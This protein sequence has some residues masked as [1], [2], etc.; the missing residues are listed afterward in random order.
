VVPTAREPRLKPEPIFL[1]LPFDLLTH[2]P[3]GSD[4]DDALGTLGGPVLFKRA[5]EQGQIV[6][7]LVKYL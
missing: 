7:S 2:R 1:L 4:V 6:G 5:A 3:G